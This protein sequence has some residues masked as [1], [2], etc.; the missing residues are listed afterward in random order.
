MILLENKIAIFNKIVFLKQ[1]EE[2]EKRIREEREKAEKILS[3]KIESLKK[4]EEA[5][6]DRRVTLAKRRG[7]E[8][9]ASVEEQKR[10]LFLEED[11]KLLNELIETLSQK[12]LEFTKTEE[13]VNLEAENFTNILDEIDEKSIYLYVKNDENKKLIEKFKEIAKEKDVELNIDELFEYHIGGFIISDME[14]TYNIN[15]SLK[16]KLEDMRYEIGSMLH[17]KLKERGEVIG[18]G[19]N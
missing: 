18:K 11:E 1:K 9:I 5:F 12:L 8:L 7:Y 14:K 4:D 16:N 15:L 19:N 6:V 10:V 3:E 17:E 13:Y 2:C